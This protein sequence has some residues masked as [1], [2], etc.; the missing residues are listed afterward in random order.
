MS[1]DYEIFNAAERND[2]KKLKALLD[3]GMDPN[4][5]DYDRGAT[6]LHL[7][8]NKGNVEAIELLID[9]G[10]DVNAANKRGRTPIHALI[11]MRFYK[12]VLWLIKYC[13]GD[14]FQADSRGLTPYDLAQQFMQKEI[15]GT[16]KRSNIPNTH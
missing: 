12:I 5:R 15:D 6:P 13:G 11:E 10:A 8:A 16:M 2:A 9:A 4:I 1:T 3:A 7:A 14:P